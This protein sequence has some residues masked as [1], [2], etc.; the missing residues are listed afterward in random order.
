MGLRDGARKHLEACSM[1]TAEAAQPGDGADSGRNSHCPQ[2]AG[3][4]GQPADLPKEERLTD[5]RTPA[6]GPGRE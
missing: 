4:L 2:S 5:L 1:R 3:L 6:Q